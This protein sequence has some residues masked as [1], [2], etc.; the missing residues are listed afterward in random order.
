MAAESGPNKAVRLLHEHIDAVYHHAD[1]AYTTEPRQGRS[2]LEHRRYSITYATSCSRNLSIPTYQRLLG[3]GSG[4]EVV[5][6]ANMILARDGYLPLY[7]TV[8]VGQSGYTIGV[9]VYM[10]PGPFV[11]FR[12]K[13]S[14]RYR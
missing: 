6:W 8:F 5:A 3:V 14:F 1:S 9:G 2:D 10:Q 4:R 11:T 7:E 12:L 13:P